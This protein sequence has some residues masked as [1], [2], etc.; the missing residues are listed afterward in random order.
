MLNFPTVNDSPLAKVQSTPAIVCRNNSTKSGS[1]YSCT[2]TSKAA[3]HV[4]HNKCSIQSADMIGSSKDQRDTRSVHLAGLADKTERKVI[5]VEEDDDDVSKEARGCKELVVKL[6]NMPNVRKTKRY[7]S[8]RSNS[9]SDDGNTTVD[10]E[11]S[12]VQK[13]PAEGTYIFNKDVI[14]RSHLVSDVELSSSSSLSTDDNSEC[15]MECDTECNMPTSLEKGG[16]TV[17]GSFN[18]KKTEQATNKLSI[19]KTTITKE[20]LKKRNVRKQSVHGCE[21]ANVCVKPYIDSV[22]AVEEQLKTNKEMSNDTFMSTISNDRLATTSVC[23]TSRPC[24]KTQVV[25]HQLSVLT[26][27]TSNFVDQIAEP[28]C[29]P[30]KFKSHSSKFVGPASVCDGQTLQSISQ[31]SQSISQNSHFIDQSSEAVIQTS[32]FTNQ[33]T[34]FISLTSAS[35]NQ[36]SQCSCQPLE[37]VSQKPTSVREMSLAMNLNSEFTNQISETSS[38]GTESIRQSAKS[39][40]QT[41]TGIS[42]ISKSSSKQSSEPISQLSEDTSE[43]RTNSIA[44]AVTTCNTSIITAE[45][46]S[47]VSM[48]GYDKAQQHLAGSSNVTDKYDNKQHYA[49]DL[50]ADN[51]YADDLI[52][53]GHDTD[54]VIAAKLDDRQHSTCENNE[55]NTAQESES[56]LQE[57]E[58]LSLT[59]HTRNKTNNCNKDA[60]MSRSANAYQSSATSS[61]LIQSSNAVQSSSAVKSSSVVQSQL[62][63]V[64]DPTVNALPLNESNLEK[65]QRRSKRII[66]SKDKELSVSS[67]SLIQKTSEEVVTDNSSGVYK[68]NIEIPSVTQS[69]AHESNTG[70]LDASA[71][72]VEKPN[73]GVLAVTVTHDPK[74]HFEVTAVTVTH[75]LKPHVEVTPGTKTYVPNHL[76]EVPSVTSTHVPNHLVEVPSVTSTHVPNHL[77]EVPS[78]TTTHV[79]KPHVEDPAVSTTKVHRS[80]VEILTVN[81]TQVHESPV[82]ISETQTHVHKPHAEFLSVTHAHK[83]HADLSS[84]TKK[85]VNKSHNSVSGIIATQESNVCDANSSSN[86]FFNQ[87]TR[88]FWE[89]IIAE[90][91][92]PKPAV[93]CSTVKCQIFRWRKGVLQ[94]PTYALIPNIEKNQVAIIEDGN[95]VPDGEHDV[96]QCDNMENAKRLH[97][98]QYHLCE[99]NMRHIDK[100]PVN[101]R[102]ESAASRRLVD[103]SSQDRQKNNVL[104]VPTNHYVL[105]PEEVNKRKKETSVAVNKRSSKQTLNANINGDNNN[106][107]PNINGVNNKKKNNAKSNIVNLT[108]ISSD[109]TNESSNFICLK[110]SRLKRGKNSAATGTSNIA[111]SERIVTESERIV[112]EGET[113][114]AEGEQYVMEG[115]RNVV[116]NKNCTADLDLR[117]VRA[118]KRNVTSSSMNV[119]RKSASSKHKRKRKVPDLNASSDQNDD[120]L[121]EDVPRLNRNLND[122]L[123]SKD[124]RTSHTENNNDHI[125]RRQNE[126]FVVNQQTTSTSA[127]DIH[128]HI[129]AGK[130][131]VSSG[132]TNVS[133]KKNV[134]NKQNITNKKN[135]TSEKNVTSKKNVTSEKNITSKKNVTSEKNI[136]SKKNVTSEKN[137]IIKKNVTSEKNVT[138]KKNVT[139]EKKAAIKKVTS[140]KNV[141]SEK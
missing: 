23:Q 114:F 118:A 1:V 98:D 110:P 27:Q 68:S 40:S 85:C 7:R 76:V 12:D 54:D 5:V 20:E 25:T 93:T 13:R 46:S 45:V 67:V 35:G 11:D 123:L 61:N 50:I 97:G 90:R 131:N 8:H 139:S 38:H 135:V 96:D 73:A 100:S 62:T 127:L 24:N 81:S 9:N 63:I 87:Q 126:T 69:C 44:D 80:N 52:T 115:E 92:Q 137:V 91:K 77:V 105:N 70:A 16:K 84:V 22:V 116:G 122:D 66:E 136:T 101:M 49:A 55:D 33:I 78:V 58:S 17:D 86:N 140:K 107:N 83:P 34:E 56:L 108:S 6:F 130:R 14:K 64:V 79:P 48:I 53:D 119:A 72:Q 111:M 10:R 74:P 102:H 43:N 32:E 113:N 75:V 124:V 82:K 39:I 51:H 121:I 57:R 2:V 133:G 41:T 106:P 112:T 129:A 21:D 42:D 134:T 95:D 104:G 19:R 94:K 138:S 132:K 59:S 128:I 103:I 18:E 28:I 117:S 120:L 109:I 4:V 37:C 71:T 88:D 141:T 89:R 29:S 47:K 30:L 65:G 60:T 26:S 3:Q 125:N 36:T 99:S 15:D 31:V